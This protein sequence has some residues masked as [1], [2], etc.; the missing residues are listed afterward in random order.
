MCVAPDMGVA[1]ARRL[2]GRFMAIPNPFA[3]RFILRSM[4]QRVFEP[5]RD[6]FLQDARNGRKRGNCGTYPQVR[7]ADLVGQEQ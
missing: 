2:A 5:G 3:L 7:I 6:R 1:I 4:G